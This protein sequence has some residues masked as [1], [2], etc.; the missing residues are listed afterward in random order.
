MLT[1]NIIDDLAQN[2]IDCFHVRGSRLDYLSSLSWE[3]SFNKCLGGQRKEQ[4]EGGW[5]AI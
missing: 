3:C 2:I 4:R 1:G 5:V